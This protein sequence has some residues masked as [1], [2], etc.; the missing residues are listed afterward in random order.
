MI[1]F[2]DNE[3]E[4]GYAQPWGEKLMAARVRI[5]YRLEDLSGDTCLIMRY[6][7]V[8]PELLTAI[9]ARA[10]FISG[11]SANPDD[12][13]P[14]DQ[15]GLKAALLEKRLPAFGFCGGHQVMAEAYGA[16]L[17]PIGPLEEPEE[18]ITFAPGLKKEM[19]YKPVQLLGKHPLFEGLGSNPIF[20]HAHSWELKTLPEGFINLAA[21][22]ITA[23]QMMVHESLPLMGTQ[24]HPEY[25]TDEHPAGRI[26]IENFMKWSGIT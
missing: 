1:V 18:E 11:N 8:T 13:D 22:E 20:R 5:K 2:I 25:Y 16:T 12:Y 26:L 21:T 9:K 15:K 23:L 14:K 6:N 3:H 17:A 24:F 19:G 7:K 10:L 4:S